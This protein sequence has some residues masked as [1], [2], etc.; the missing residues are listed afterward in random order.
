MK[1]IF[2]L[3][4]ID[5]VQYNYFARLDSAD[6][7]YYLFDVYELHTINKTKAI[8]L[9]EFFTGV[10]DTIQSETNISRD[11]FPDNVDRVD[12]MIDDQNIMI[13]SNRLGAIR[14]VVNK[15]MESG[16]ILSRDINTEKMFKK[17]K[18]TR[19]MRIFK[20]INQVSTICLN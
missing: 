9:T 11:V 3:I 10:H 12:V 1:T 19:Y 16:Y 15:F 4:T 18:I 8:D 6:K 17:D 20:I 14:H 5:K 13:E 2:N 7:L